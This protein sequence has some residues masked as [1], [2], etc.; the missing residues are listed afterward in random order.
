MNFVFYLQ[1]LAV[2]KNTKTCCINWRSKTT[3]NWQA[4]ERIYEYIKY[5][6]FHAWT[7]L[8]YKQRK[9]T[10]LFGFKLLPR[11]R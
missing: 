6:E 7:K 4:R 8:E 3:V 1:R 11:S 5:I 10:Q 2:K 9:F